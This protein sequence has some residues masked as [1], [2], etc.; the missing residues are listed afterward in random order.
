MRLKA[1]LQA[2]ILSGKILFYVVFSMISAETSFAQR[3]SKSSVTGKITDMQS[4]SPLMYASIRLFKSADSS[5]VTGGVTDE[6][7][8]FSVEIAPGAYYALSEFIG[9]KSLTT[10]GIVLTNNAPLNLGNL[11]LTASARTLDEVTVQAEKSSMELALDKKIFNVGKDLANAGGTAV[12][13]LTNIPSV[14]VDVEGNVSLR[15]SG[16]VRILIDGKPSGLVSIK[17]GAGLQQLQG[18]IIERVEIITN[19]SARYEAEGMSGIINIVLKKERKEGFNGSFD[20]IAGQ[21]T[22]F[23]VAANVNYRRKNLNFFINYTLSFRNTPGRNT[24]YQELYRNDSV[25]ISEK[26]MTS[27]LKGQNNSARGGLDYY[28]NSKNVLTA[29]YT[30]RISN[31]KRFSNINYKDYLSDLGNLL[32]RTNRTQDETEKEPNSEYALTYKK[33]FDRKGQEFTADVR[34]LDNWEDS[35]QFYGQQRYNKDGSKSSVPFL[36]QRAVNFETEKQLLFQADYVHPFAKDGKVEAGARTSSRDMTNDYAVTEETDAGWISVPG[37]TNDFLYN[38]RI[39]AAYGI[40]GNKTGRFS[41]QAGLRAEWTGVKTTLKQ[42]NEVNER[43]YAN[44]FP[45]VHVT[46]DLAKQNALQL[47]FSR[48][49]RRPQ[50]ND[51]SPFATYSDN[52]NYWSGNPDLNPEFTNAFELGHIKYLEKGSFS[53]SLYYRHTNGKI[54]SIKSVESDGTSFT[55]PEN[56]GTED[57]YGAEFTTSHNLYSWWKLDGSFNFFRSMIDG[58]QVDQSF[59][60]DTYSWFV[61]TTSRLTLWKSTDLQLRGNYEAPQKTPQGR[62]K[63]MA[64]LDLAASRDILKGKATLTLSVLDVFNSRRFRSITEGANFYT[65]SNSQGRRRQANLTLNYRL[66][67]AKKKAKDVGEGDY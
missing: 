12:D 40:I 29:A 9:Y 22:N 43:N 25:F 3:G 48:R 18:N 24:L 26:S 59:K 53:S 17:G 42:T 61:R 65:V 33:T 39:S 36:L 5:F 31:G 50:Y 47:S 10:S 64:T 2:A 21:P 7:G 49:V 28:F 45:S 62:R 34:Y 32:G 11:K 52:R 8:N 60:S 54:M 13:I 23:G 55:R 44:L 15:G 57:A 41:Y 35:D 58:T 20:L 37:L 30:Y 19:P 46:Y 6:T 1:P 67:Q 4:N 66:H 38:E 27:K 14:A 63:E 16:N 56:L 51:L